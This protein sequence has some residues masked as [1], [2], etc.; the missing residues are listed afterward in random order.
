[1][2]S[3]TVL[4]AVFENEGYGETT[5]LAQVFWL[6]DRGAPPARLYVCA[7]RDLQIT[8]DFAD[9]GPDIAGLRKRLRSGGIEIFDAYTQYAAQVRRRFSMESQ[10]PL[11]L[12]HQTVSMKTVDSLTGFVRAHMLNPPDDGERV[13]RLI[14]HFDDLN[15][16]HEDVL[17][18]E[19]QV[20]MLG[21]ML[22]TAR[23]HAD[24]GREADRLRRC[25]DALK[26]YFAKLKLALLD[27]RIADLEAELDVMRRTQETKEALE[28]EQIRNVEN[29]KQSIALNGGSRIEK[30][31]EEAERLQLALEDRKK[32]ADRYEGEL[33]LIGETMPRTAKAFAEQQARALVLLENLSKEFDNLS[34]RQR[35]AGVRF[36]Q[37]RDKH[38]E[39]G[40]ELDSL[41]S[42]P[43][44]IDRAQ[45]EI[46][47][48]MCD[49]LGLREEELPFAG[50]MIQVRAD[51][52]DWEGAIERM[53]RPFGLTMLVP[54]R[55]YADVAAWVDENNLRGR[56]V[57]HL[58]RGSK[59]HQ[60][61]GGSLST[62][63]LAR[64]LQVKPSMELSHWLEG[65]VRARFGDVVC[66]ES[67]DQF[68]FERRA[69]SKAGQIKEP[70]GRHEKDDRFDLNNRRRF[71]LGWT[72]QAKI[73][74]L[75]RE[76]RR[77]EEDCQGLSQ[78][79]TG[80]QAESHRLRDK[81]VALSS[82][83]K[84]DLFEEIDWRGT[85]IQ[86]DQVTR[87]RKE[88][89]NSSDVLK[90]LN[91][92]LRD[93]EL[94]RDALQEEINGLDKA[95]GA[96]G[97]KH[98]A[99]VKERTAILELAASATSEPTMLGYLDAF[100]REVI[101]ERILSVETCANRETDVREEITAR[102]DAREGR[103]RRLVEK[104]L[105]Q[106][107][108]FKSA[109]PR[110]TLEVD[111]SVEAVPEFE[112]MLRT[113]EDDDLP[114]FR[115]R[116]KELLNQETIRE[117]AGFQAQ[118]AKE[119]DT[120][121]ERVD[122]INESL[123]PIDFN[124]DRYIFLDA[125]PT[126]DA[127]IREFQADLR[128]CTEGALT[129]SDDE[130][131]SEAKFMQVRA[132]IDRLKGREGLRD[133]DRAWTAKVTD[134]RNWFSFAADER[135]RS[136]DTSHEHYSDS[137]GKSGGQKEKLA[138]TILA[139]SLA[140]Q[141]GLNSTATRSR[142]FRFVVIDEAFGRGSDTSA[143]YALRLFESIGIQLLVV[144]P[145]QKIHVIE[146]YVLGV[147]YVQINDAG[148]CSRLTNMSIEEYRKRK[149]EF[150]P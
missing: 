71:V 90:E 81:Q 111:A 16:A 89:E 55:C 116:F 15:K 40:S 30:L 57:Y 103:S 123:K 78:V 54:E 112:R 118:L 67:P 9:F 113:L 13:A 105:K 82:L 18:A 62:L 35:D 17:R 65:E 46:R 134:V 141:F 42:R 87:E 92:H 60:E 80:L 63:A 135:W 106:M 130:Q 51:Q 124:R 58:V 122:V 64:K 49:A 48:L 21:P 59:R 94:R 50:E 142:G 26:A 45:I 4:L 140:Y 32:K 143:T 52:L 75:E 110:E 115:I 69:L 120:I 3:Y 34:E 6:K 102:I 27:D 95:L 29:I 98:E 144:T 28:Q 25:R 56:L 2:N 47:R 41:R 84:F 97:E 36:Q 8:R 128:A 148:D 119:R 86:I 136:D 66:C 72:N 24:E 70:G 99:A 79:L 76:Q 20:L 139:A 109:F 101:G 93:A 38:A 131:Y 127:E 31:R 108:E 39:I 138:Y 7:N 85:V 107:S 12:F 22:T 100:R 88:L 10:Q 104:L 91:Q 43:S 33:K 11:E 61:A 126:Q 53:L 114:R 19:R 1:M 23:E 129:G 117:I 145:L 96:R 133:Q 74:E 121:K 125:Y 73:S 132:I 137:G 83:T 147:G 37:A 68:R 146:P 44:N 77:L 149:S 5:T 14:S 150:A